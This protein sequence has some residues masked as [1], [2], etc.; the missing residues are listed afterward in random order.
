MRSLPSCL[1]A[2]ASTSL[3]WVWP[4]CRYSPS[5]SAFPHHVTSSC[6]SPCL[7]VFAWA[8][9][10]SLLLLLLLSS[11]SLLLFSPLLC[12]S[13]WV[14]EAGHQ[15]V[16]AFS[17]T[18][19]NQ[20]SLPSAAPQRRTPPASLPS[21]TPQ[22]HPHLLVPQALPL[23]VSYSSLYLTAT[24]SST[25]SSNAT[26]LQNCK[27]CFVLPVFLAFHHAPPC[28][29]I[30]CCILPPPNPELNYAPGMLCASPA[31][32][33][34]CDPLCCRRALAPVLGLL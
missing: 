18:L 1:E 14:S 31:M 9:K 20:G 30:L 5:S 3:A 4:S 32:L 22:H 21:I 16:I 25:P 28:Q 15:A 2:G 23:A 17:I 26:H 6:S 10:I 34:S 12:L 8:G 13:S 7:L 27:A 33:T 11:L 19:S 29:P 24:P